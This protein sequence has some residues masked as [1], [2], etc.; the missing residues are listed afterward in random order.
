MRCSEAFRGNENGVKHSR[1]VTSRFGTPRNVLGEN[2]KMLRIVQKCLKNNKRLKVIMYA[3]GL[4]RGT[5]FEP[6]LMPPR[7]KVG[8]WK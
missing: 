8:H 7:D 4:S 1:N 3:F 6:H 5:S 2:K